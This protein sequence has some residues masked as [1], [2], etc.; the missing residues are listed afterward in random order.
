MRSLLDLRK[1]NLERR[2]RHAEH[3]RY[4]D[5]APARVDLR[6]CEHAVVVRAVGG[7]DRQHD[8]FENADVECGATINAGGPFIICSTGLEH[9]VFLMP[10]SGTLN[11]RPRFVIADA[12]SRS[13]GRGD[14]TSLSRACEGRRYHQQACR[15]CPPRNGLAHGFHLQSA[16]FSG[17]VP[18]S[19]MASST[20]SMRVMF[21]A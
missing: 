15:A 11:W 16:R 8:L 9:G 6:M 19:R 18:I 10:V 5:S 2:P 4:N 17:T 13:R 7:S 3:W 21:P 14:S 1:Y 12:H 20:D